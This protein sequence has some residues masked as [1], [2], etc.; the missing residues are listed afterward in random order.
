MHRRIRLQPKLA[1]GDD[2]LAR[3]KSACDDCLIPFY[4]PNMH[5][6][7]FDTFIRAYRVHVW[8]VVAILD[9]HCRYQDGIRKV[10]Q[11]DL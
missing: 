9:G 10:V 8:T 7:C 5:W 3:G 6:T 4:G 11:C 2:C 1:F